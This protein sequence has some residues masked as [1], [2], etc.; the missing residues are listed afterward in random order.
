VQGVVARGGLVSYKHNP[1]GTQSPYELNVNYFDALAPLGSPEPAVAQVNRFMAGQAIMLALAGLPGIYFHSLVGS[2]GWPE[3]VGLTGR[4]RTINREKLALGVLERELSDVHHRRSQIFR[5]YRDLLAARAASAA[6]D[7]SGDQRV[8]DLDEHVFSLL[9]RSPDGREVVVCLH[10]VSDAPRRV[11]LDRREL[12]AAQAPISLIDGRPLAGDN[13][14]DL[15][16]TL[17]PYDVRW[18][19]AGTHGA[20][21]D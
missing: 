4:N 20:P 18:I 3:G 12:G 2:R 14:S 6:F 9:R 17:A 21:P 11:T 15:R 13:D 19:A 5:R 16:L 7:P 10:N 1:D 8:L